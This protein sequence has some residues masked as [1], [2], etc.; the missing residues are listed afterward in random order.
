MTA[1]PEEIAVRELLAQYEL[2]ARVGAK[3]WQ[4]AADASADEARAL[5]A[6]LVRNPGRAFEGHPAYPNLSPEQIEEARARAWGEVTRAEGER[7]YAEMMA[8][9]Y[10][11]VRTYALAALAAEGGEQLYELG[12]VPPTERQ[13]RVG[14]RR[15]A[16]GLTDESDHSP[17]PAHEGGDMTKAFLVQHTGEVLGLEICGDPGIDGFCGPCI[18]E[19]GHTYD[20]A[21]T[22]PRRWKVEPTT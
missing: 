18:L 11:R 8:R 1:S 2:A 13:P 20:H 22:T 9:A 3:D 7:L 19:K 14:D 15:R 21:D 16:L 6:S 12:E 10:L 4:R 5:E 17:A